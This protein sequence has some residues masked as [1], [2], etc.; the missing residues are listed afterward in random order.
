MLL[1]GIEL[2][3]QMGYMIVFVL[4]LLG[5]EVLEFGLDLCEF[6]LMFL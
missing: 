1:E 6:E 5:G 4:E 2:L 3:L